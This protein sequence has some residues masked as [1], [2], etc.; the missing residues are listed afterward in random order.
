[1]LVACAS[2]LV[3]GKDLKF[4]GVRNGPLK[5]VHVGERRGVEK[6]RECLLVT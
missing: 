5:N 1:M 6:K 2:P 3:I 4:E